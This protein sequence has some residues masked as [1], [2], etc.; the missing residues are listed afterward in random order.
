MSDLFDRPMFTSGI[1]EEQDK[2]IDMV[3]R[4]KTPG[5]AT[6]QQPEN[7][8]GITYPVST[9]NY[10]LGTTGIGEILALTKTQVNPQA[11]RDQAADLMPAKSIDEIAQ[12][13]DSLYAPEAREPSNFKFDKYLALARFGVGLMQPT[14]G[15]TIAP[16][17]AKAGDNFVKDLANIAQRQR[18]EEARIGKIEADDERTRRNFILQS[19]QASE[20]A[21]LALQSQL[22]AK[23][24]Q[25]NMDNDL[26]DKNYIRELNKMFYNYQYTTDINAMKKHYDIL[27]KQHNK[28]GKVLFDQTSGKFAMGYIQN[29]EQGIPIP[30]FPVN[31]KG[32]FKFVA[33]PEAI[34]TNFTLNNRGD[35]DPGSKEIMSLSAKINN[36]K[37]ALKFIRDVQASII[38]DPGIVGVPGFFQQF[39]QSAGSTLFDIA[40]ALKAKGVIDKGAYDRNVN[41]IENNVINHLKE[42]YVKYND[43][44]NANNFS[45]EA[46]QG[47]FEYDIYRT[48]FNPEIPKNQVRLNSIYYALARARKATG[49]LNVDDINNAREAIDLYGLGGSDTIKASLNIVYE[50]IENQLKSDLLAFNKLGPGYEELIADIPYTEF[51]G[52]SAGQDIFISSTQLQTDFT[53]SKNSAS[54]GLEANDATV[55]APAFDENLTSEPN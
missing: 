25:F 41:R 6:D 55:G 13:Y 11:F 32:V 17:L 7:N 37:Q 44:P 8:V 19:A 35:F 50:Q 3:N 26:R 9:Y 42:N 33:R 16:A 5:Q 53:P 20:N 34:V 54:V 49:R 18:E 40:D 27:Q 43:D 39:T 28:E 46:G 45:T 21:S 38:A 31:E 4:P 47:S 36:T 23:A 12:T 15:G 29:N 1:S 14:P 2:A 52:Q 22:I 10:P 24:F 30:Y 48:F 51:I